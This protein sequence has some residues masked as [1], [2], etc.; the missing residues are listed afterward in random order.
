MLL[1]QQAAPYLLLSRHLGGKLGQRIV[2]CLGIKTVGQLREYPLSMLQ[3][4]FGNKTG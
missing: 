4:T 3:K 1:W 2:E